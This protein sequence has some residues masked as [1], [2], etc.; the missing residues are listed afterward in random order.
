MISPFVLFP[1]RAAGEGH[2]EVLEFGHKK[3]ANFHSPFIVV[4]KWSTTL[5]H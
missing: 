1:A 3:R 5:F 2:Q 4:Y